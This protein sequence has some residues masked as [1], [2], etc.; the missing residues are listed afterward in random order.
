VFQKQGKLP[1]NCS[2]DKWD[3]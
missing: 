1:P 3:Q 2:R